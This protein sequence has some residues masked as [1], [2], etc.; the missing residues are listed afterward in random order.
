MDKKKQT[1]SRCVYTRDEHCKFLGRK[2]LMLG[3]KRKTQDTN[4]SNALNRELCSQNTMD[5]MVSAMHWVTGE[6]VC[7]AAEGLKQALLSGKH[8]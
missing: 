1:G 6:R 2:I 3:L 7:L 5:D 4:C 8:R